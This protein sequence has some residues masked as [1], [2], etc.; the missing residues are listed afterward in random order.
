MDCKVKSCAACTRTCWLVHGR[1]SSS[2]VVASFFKVML[3]DDF[4]KVLFLPPQFASEMS[5]LV[6]ESALLEDSNGRQWE[7]TVSSVNGSLVFHR[8]WNNFSVSHDLE[9]GDFV[10]FFQLTESLFVVKI[11]DK[12]ACERVSFSKRCYQRKRSRGN[13]ISTE[14]DGPNT[15]VSPCS[16]IEV[17]C[18]INRDLG[19]QGEEDRICDL[20]L[21]LFET[22][23]YSGREGSSQDC[24]T[25]GISPLPVAKSVG[26]G[27]LH[28]V[29]NSSWHL[30][31]MSAASKALAGY[32][33]FSQFQKLGSNSTQMKFGR[34]SASSIVPTSIGIKNCQSGKRMK[35]IKEEP[36]EILSDTHKQETIQMFPG[37]SNTSTLTGTKDCQSGRIMN[38]VKAEPV[39]I[40]SSPCS[41]K[42]IQNASVGSPKLTKSEYFR[43][44]SM[45]VR[46][47][48]KGAQVAKTDRAAQVAKPDR[49]SQMAKT[50]KVAQVAKTNRVATTDRADQVEKTDRA[51]QVVKT[52]SVVQVEKGESVDLVGAKNCQTGDAS[53]V[54]EDIVPQSTVPQELEVKTEVT[55]LDG[56]TVPQ[57]PVVKTEITDLDG[58]YPTLS[59]RSID[60]EVVVKT[61]IIDVDE[62]SPA[63]SPLLAT[64]SESFVELP[65]YL[66]FPLTRG[67]A[68]GLRKTVILRD[69]ANRLWPVLYHGKPS[70]KCLAFGWGA[71]RK[72][73][74]IKPGDQ[75]RFTLEN[76]NDGIY[77]VAVVPR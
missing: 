4:S 64:C 27:A 56:S 66:L 13:D 18:M 54:T 22:Y 43:N 37:T 77:T 42:T 74:R 60:P 47:A 51:A 32:N 34:V 10:V 28:S 6:D 49:V 23:K 26:S 20:D 2:P 36:A 59:P 21:S 57:E 67:K 61:E 12:T 25:S 48:K 58:S 9:I 38:A 14:N 70:L 31:P 44:V 62:S 69:P 55:D 41:Q 39:E 53:R 40:K 63:F 75:C 46:Q 17:Y 3:G 24:V 5:L 29:K 52:D 15:S 30:L 68:T 7:V 72:A 50:D 11:Y 1:K 65:G 8:G 45:S 71:L 73:N 16:D 76:K 35:V 19:E 33:Q